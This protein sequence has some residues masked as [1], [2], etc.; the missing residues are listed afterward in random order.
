MNVAGRTSTN[1]VSL[2]ITH[3]SVQRN[4]YSK[5]IYLLFII[6]NHLMAYLQKEN[7][8]NGQKNKK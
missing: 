7:N 4:I 8:S 6:Y 3:C 1:K 2:K 5:L